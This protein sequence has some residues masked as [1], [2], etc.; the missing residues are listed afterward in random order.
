MLQNVNWDL[1]QFWDQTN[2]K[3]CRSNKN[4]LFE[5]QQ[6]YSKVFLARNILP[7]NM[8]DVVP[9]KSLSGSP[10]SDQSATVTLAVGDNRGSPG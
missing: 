10:G 2:N 1:L 9:Y 7:R 6:S 4:L 3:A 5:Q 8:L